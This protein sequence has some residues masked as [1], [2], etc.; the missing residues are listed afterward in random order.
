MLEMNY[1]VFQGKLMAHCL[2]IN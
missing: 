1:T 2:R